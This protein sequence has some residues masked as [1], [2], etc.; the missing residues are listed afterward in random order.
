MD[1]KLK[2]TALFLAC[3]LALT[4]CGGSS[5]DSGSNS[6]PSNGGSTLSD[7]DKAKGF[8]DTVNAMISGVQNVQK[9]YQRATTLTDNM[10]S[11]G[12][13]T[14]IVQAVI[15]LIIEDSQGSNKT[16]NATQINALLQE[17]G[18]ELTNSTLTATINQDTLTLSGGF[19]YKPLEGWTANQVNGQWVTQP[20]YAEEI[21]AQVDNLKASV[22]FLNNNKELRLN[23]VQG[24]KISAKTVNTANATLEARSDSTLTALFDR[25]IDTEQFEDGANLTNASFSFKN[26]LLNIGGTAQDSIT[27][28][29]L[30]ATAQAATIQT[31]QE[32]VIQTVPTSL[33][34]IGKVNSGDAKDTADINLSIK[35]NNDL[36][37][38]I[39]LGEQGQETSVSFANVDINL[40]VSAKVRTG[41][42]L[43]T[44]LAA[45]RAELGKGEISKLELELNGKKLTGQAWIDLPVNNQVE[46]IKV[47]L[48]DAQGAS[49][50][51]NDIDQFTT[52]DIIV[53]NKSWGTITKQ[54]NGMYI[55]RFND[56]T[57]KTIAP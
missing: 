15:A 53:N 28:D 46:K 57:T 32:T 42:T 23:L 38:P 44:T 22:A 6:N 43:K 27:L 2:V 40:S 24:S 19:N 3:S 7:Q 47:M 25:A 9:T 10:S 26:M 31:G 36:S 33:K 49:V 16:Y 1:S 14:T 34:L 37:K 29:E 48:A 12:E 52:T 20:V 50:T 18:Y 11:L 35:L 8:V 21:I 13:S 39:A 51:V 4:G 56:N 54:S 45:K 41:D 55:A 17:E 30:S 5:S